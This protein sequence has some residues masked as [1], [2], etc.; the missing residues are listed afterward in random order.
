MKGPHED[1]EANEATQLVHHDDEENHHHHHHGSRHLGES[2]PL[3]SPPRQ[4][5]RWTDTQILPHVNWGDL[6]FDL[7][8]VA[9]AY[10]L[11]GIM[12]HDPSF[13]GLVYFCCCYPPIFQIWGDK[14]A[15]DAKYAPNDNIFHRAAEVLHLAIVG[16]A[17]QHVQPVSIMSTTS[18]Y[19]DTMIFAAALFVECI[20]RVHRLFDVYYN[21][22]G[23][24]EAR[25]QSSDDIRRKVATS[26]FYLAA[27]LVAGYD[28]FFQPPT[29]TTND[30]PILLCG[31]AYVFEILYFLSNLYCIVPN[32]R[33]SMR[34]IRV[35]MNLE[36]TLHRMGEWVML[37]LGESVLSLLIAPQSKGARYYVTFYTGILAVTQLQYL[38]FRTQ[39]FEARDHATRRSRSGGFL[40]TWMLV[41]YSGSLIVF[42]GAYK[43]T[44][45]Q[46]LLMETKG[47]NTLIGLYTVAEREQRIANLFC[48]SL[49]VSM[50]TLDIMLIAHRGAKDNLA[51]LFGN[52]GCNCVPFMVF[53]FDI[54]LN[55]F[56]VTLSRW[57]TSLETLSVL[58][59]L[60]V[61]SHLFLRVFGLRYFPVS[62]KE[63]DRL[64]GRTIDPPV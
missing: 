49:T 11:D 53:L 7:F 48:W 3:Y 43:L 47:P 27:A 12:E 37:M 4:R 51:R 25:H 31:A 20:S 56:T 32:S 61:T 22:E 40:F 17:I 60:I 59:C 52:T 64:L 55:V 39:P 54:A 26:M 42:G 41:V 19:P 10:N 36:F 18:R 16:T 62:K 46:Y 50:V 33:L 15:Y 2:I 35:P 9:A 13:R 58:G 29:N 5:Q 14:L 21:V 44:L 63:M 6:F 28:Y 23:G 30:V 8:Y 45:D 57:V 24:D 34:E 1:K 38:F